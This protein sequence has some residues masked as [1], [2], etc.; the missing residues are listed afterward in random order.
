LR[1]QPDGSL[2]ELKIPEPTERQEAGLFCRCFYDFSVEHGLLVATYH[3][4]SGREDP[5]VIKYRWNG[6]GKE[7]QVAEV[8]AAPRYKASFDCDKANTAV[9]NAI[10]NSS[11]VASLDVTLNAR[12]R[13]WLE[14]LNNTESDI[15]TKEQRE[16]LHK[17]DLIC[18][19]DMEIFDCLEILYRAR[20]LEVE[21]FRHLHAAGAAP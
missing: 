17:R 5:L 10:C 16:W 13:G 4:Q 14:T 9:E 6:S 11:V 18:G 8:K 1:R 15:L 2:A 7:F 3:D 19:N 21:H 20:V 12:Y